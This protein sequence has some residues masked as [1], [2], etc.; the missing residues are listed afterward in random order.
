MAC[1]SR[2]QFYQTDSVLM[3]QHRFRVRSAF[4]KGPKPLTVY[5]LLK[6]FEQTGYALNN[7]RGN[8]G[9]QKSIQTPEDIVHVYGLII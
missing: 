2:K 6:Q 4:R 1:I 8:A 7:T 5:R 3:V 9:K